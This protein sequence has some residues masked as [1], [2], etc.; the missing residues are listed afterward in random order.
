MV[1]LEPRGDPHNDQGVCLPD[2]APGRLPSTDEPQGVHLDIQYPDVEIQVNRTLAVTE[3]FLAIPH[4][5]ALAVVG[6][7]AVA[8][9]VIAWFVILIAGPLPEGAV[10]VRG[11]G[12][13]LGLEGR[14]LRFPAY[15]R[16]VPAV[17]VWRIAPDSLSAKT[18]LG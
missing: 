9:T 12:P 15:H 2:A 1:R 7:L 6:T 17:P 3:W 16:Q 13:A 5:I 4:Y 18:L 10:P 8:V 14:G 11:G